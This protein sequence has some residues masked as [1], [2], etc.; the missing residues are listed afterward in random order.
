MGADELSILFSVSAGV[1]SVFPVCQGHGYSALEASMRFQYHTA[2]LLIRHCLFC[3]AKGQ[4]RT[5]HNSSLQAA[6]HHSAA[7]SAQ[8]VLKLRR[9]FYE[10]FIVRS[11]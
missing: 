5:A 8:S 4:E 1:A 2:A 7:V 11:S 10:V 3:F 9:Y 6:N